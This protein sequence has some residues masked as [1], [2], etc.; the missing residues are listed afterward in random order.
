MLRFTTFAAALLGL[1]VALAPGAMA[2]EPVEGQA[3][4]DRVIVVDA[5]DLF[6]VS[7]ET[8][9]PRFTELIGREVYSN[10]GRR[11]G[12]IEDF[13]MARGG[14]IYA[15]VDIAGGPVHDLLTLGEGEVLILPLREIRQAAMP[16]PESRGR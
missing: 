7:E 12:E 9:E 2:A 5:P 14:E 15:V 16:G 6:R 8:V 3:T 4:E 13:V 1:A 10:A 11:I